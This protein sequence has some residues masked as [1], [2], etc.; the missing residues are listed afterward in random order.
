MPLRIAYPGAYY[1]VMTRGNNKLELFLDTA[2]RFTYLN[3]LNIGISEFNIR[4]HAYA[5]MTNHVHLCVET[6][7][8]NISEGMYRLNL[9]YNRYF[10]SKYR[11]T[12]HLFESRFNSR[13][14]QKDRYFLALVRYIHVNPVK[15][16]MALKPENYFWSSHRAYL[17]G[18]DSVIENPAEAM[19]IF[20]D[21]PENARKLYVEFI[22]QNI[23]DKEWRLLDSKRNGLLGDRS[24][25]LAL[26]KR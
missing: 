17:S 1:H 4:V 25:R 6:P 8:A 11:R 10:N 22:N 16:G 14:V 21:N 15:A 19:A 23:S 2:D 20:S 12:G 13:L 24:F 5:L 7:L 3:L 26:S 9:D 18:G